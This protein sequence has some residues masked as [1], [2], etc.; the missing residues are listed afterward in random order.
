MNKQ[1]SFSSYAV[2]FRDFFRDKISL[3]VGCISLIIFIITYF[4][5]FQKKP[6][7]F[8][9]ARQN[10]LVH[11]YND[12]ID[13]GKSVI[14]DSLVTDTCAGLSFILKEG[15]IRPYVGIS[16][17]NKSQNEYDVSFYN[18]VKIEASGVRIKPIFVYMVLRDST[19][20]F[21]GKLLQIRQLCQYIEI[22]SRRSS[23]KLAMDDFKTPDWW[24]DKYNLSPATIDKPDFKHLYRLTLATGLTPDLNR[25]Q[26]FKVYSIQFYR[27]NG[28]V[29]FRMVMLQLLIM[30]ILLVIFYYRRNPQKQLK[31]LTVNYNA[32]TVA[33][34]QENG[35]SFLEYINENFHDTELSLQLIARHTGHSQRTISESIFKQYHCNVKTYIN[36]IRINEAIRLLRETHLNISE[37]AYKVGFNSP[38]NF[39]RV[40]KNLTGK[41]PS[42]FLQHKE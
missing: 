14:T 38:S 18:C 36:Q 25:I 32:V 37:I 9:P 24:F 4:A 42:E 21:K 13:D 34:K 35:I 41:T 1:V 8:F 3:S 30:A 28:M 5:V 11:F 15:F 7:Q 16:I 20:N 33:Q 29:I 12:K 22:S 2:F 31:T 19:T 10:T 39:N 27:D 17:D 6:L 26:S 23:F 40:F